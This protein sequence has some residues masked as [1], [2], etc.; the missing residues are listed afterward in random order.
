MPAGCFPD[1]W[2]DGSAG[3]NG[4]DGR[5]G[6]GWFSSR[7]FFALRSTV[8]RAARCSHSPCSGEWARW[9]F[10]AAESIGSEQLRSRVRGLP[11]FDP[12]GDI[13]SPAHRRE[14]QSLSQSET[15]T[16]S[17]IRRASERFRYVGEVASP[18]SEC[19]L[20]RGAADMFSQGA[21]SSNT[22]AYTCRLNGTTN[23]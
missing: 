20:R 12:E 22:R 9:H 18:G 13:R 19:T 8:R 17:G 15:P 3:G 10:L 2:T 16:G 23:S 4:G 11:P 14:S 6:R 7:K 5:T 1:L 21:N